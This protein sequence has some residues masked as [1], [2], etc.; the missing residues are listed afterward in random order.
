MLES[1]FPVLKN[2]G[3]LIKNLHCYTKTDFSVLIYPVVTMVGGWLHQGSVDN[4]LG[5]H[6]TDAEKGR[7][8]LEQQVSAE[9][10]PTFLSTCRC[11]IY[12]CRRL[13]DL[14]PCFVYPC[15]R[16]IDL[17]L[18]FVY[19]CRRLIDLSLC[20]AYPCRRLTDL[21]LIAAHALDDLAVP[22]ENSRP[23]AGRM[24]CRASCVSTGSANLH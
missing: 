13:I 7:Y 9:T 14:S 12:P 4:L 17:S 1:W 15:R 23:P 18:C 24:T 3:F 5:E 6:P 20:F 11:C 8:S 16:L 21:S 22:V 10:P 2:L 19:P